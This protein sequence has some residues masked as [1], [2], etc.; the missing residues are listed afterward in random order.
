MTEK[1]ALTALLKVVQSH[2]A[3]KVCGRWLVI[4]IDLWFVTVEIVQRWQIGIDRAGWR[5][6]P[7]WG[8]V[9]ESA[10]PP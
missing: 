7:F 10:T 5:S 2:R 1:E 4:N 6:R 8:R 3:Y 9:K